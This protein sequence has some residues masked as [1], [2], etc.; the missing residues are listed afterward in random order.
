MLLDKYRSLTS[1]DLGD[2]VR[3][4]ADMDGSSV[5]DMGGGVVSDNGFG[6]HYLFAVVVNHLSRIRLCIFFLS[7]LCVDD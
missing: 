4:T 5:D 1:S 2:S 3:S 7:F 6:V